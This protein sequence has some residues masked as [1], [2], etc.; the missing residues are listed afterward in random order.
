MQSVFIEGIFQDIDYEGGFM[1][2]GTKM[3]G[4]G[5]ND[6]P[7]KLIFKRLYRDK[8]GGLRFDNCPFR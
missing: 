3:I 7:A 5:F 6:R 8:K 1:L 4:S 2:R